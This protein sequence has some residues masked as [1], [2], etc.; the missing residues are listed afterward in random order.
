[1]GRTSSVRPGSATIVYLDANALA[2][3]VTRTLLLVGG[4]PSGF[5]SIWSG[6]AEQEAARHLR[7]RAVTPADVC[8]RFGIALGPSAEIKGRFPSTRGN[9]RQILADAEAAGARFLVTG[10]VDDLAEVD[11]VSVGIAAANPDLFLAER[12]TPEA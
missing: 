4:L 11:L 9:D 5:H 8:H 3:P 10:D 12:L 1:M 2:K 6:A 7:S